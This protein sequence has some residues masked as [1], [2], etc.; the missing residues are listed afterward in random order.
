[1]DGSGDKAGLDGHSPSFIMVGCVIV[2]CVVAV[3]LFCSD[4]WSL[5]GW[6]L[7]GFLADGAVI[8]CCQFG[9]KSDGKLASLVGVS[10]SLLASVDDLG[11][12]PRVGASASGSSS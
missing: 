12:L 4:C 3:C 7:P 11:R 6:L 1:M 9:G 2:D 5:I 10:V 8:G